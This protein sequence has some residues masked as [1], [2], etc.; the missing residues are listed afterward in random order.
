MITY[1]MSIHR[2]NSA[3]N[4]KIPTHKFIIAF[5]IR[6]VSFSYK[7]DREKPSGKINL[8]CFASNKVKVI[9]SIRMK[10]V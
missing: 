8:K 10:T 7:L 1:G 6:A 2:T 5:F 4:F 3:R 9:F